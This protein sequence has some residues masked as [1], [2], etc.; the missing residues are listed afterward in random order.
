MLT[1]SSFPKDRLMALEN[2]A[3]DFLTKSSDLT[4]FQATIKEIHI[5]WMETSALY[6]LAS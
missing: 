3:S 5:K 1:T 6:N 2:N 4:S